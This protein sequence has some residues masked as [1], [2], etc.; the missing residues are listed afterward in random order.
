[1]EPTTAGAHD[2]AAA[3]RS[4]A[5]EAR[6]AA[7]FGRVEEAIAPLLRGIGRAAAPPA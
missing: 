6:L 2:L 4:F 5:T 1:M 7:A 3:E